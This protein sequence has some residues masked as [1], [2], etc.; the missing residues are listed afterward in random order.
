MKKLFIFISFIFITTF[1]FSQTQK[2]VVWYSTYEF[3]VDYTITEQE[4]PV[5][6][7]VKVG[8]ILYLRKK[9]KTVDD[10]GNQT[11][12]VNYQKYPQTLRKLFLTKGC[13]FV[14]Y[15]KSDQ[16]GENY[17]SYMTYVPARVICI[18]KE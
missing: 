11:V 4:V 3:E 15:M 9:D 12:F 6:W 1:S 17:T 13:N 2:T 10:N 5:F 7:N 8:D 18:T 16:T 14:V